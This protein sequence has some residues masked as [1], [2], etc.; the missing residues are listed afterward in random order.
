MKNAAQTGQMLTA[1]YIKNKRDLP[2]RNTRDPYAIWISEIMLQQTR[3]DTVLEYYR[4][5]LLCFPDV[6]TLAAA[7]EEEVLS[8]WQGLGYYSRARNLHQASRVI[9]EKYSGK[10]PQSL[11]EVRALPGIGAYTAGAVLSIAFDQTY[12]AVDGNVLRVIS[13]L[14]GSEVDI[15]LEKVKKQIGDIVLTMIPE[16]MARDFNQALMELGAMVCTPANP[17][18]QGCPIQAD[19]AAYLS[20]RQ[21]ELPFKKK[22]DKTTEPVQYWLVIIRQQEKILMEYRKNINLLGNMWGF[23]MVE[24]SPVSTPEKQFEEQYGLILRNLKPLGPVRHVFTHQ[25]WQIEV[26]EA[27][28][29]EPEILR[30]LPQAPELRWIAFKDLK[31]LPIPTAFQKVIQMRSNHSP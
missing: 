12:P 11:D 17:D 31:G 24:K 26:V 15:T 30:E 27:V 13:R 9:V 22:K 20:G 16:G 3:V 7:D 18:C 19:C 29:A 14:E 25:I 10:F 28:L 1:W 5:F 8:L 6:F 23:P 2:W 21:R 4:R